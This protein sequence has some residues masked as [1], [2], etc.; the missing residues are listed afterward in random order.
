MVVNIA[1]WEKPCSIMPNV[2]C[3][4]ERTYIGVATYQEG[5]FQAVLD[6]IASGAM[7]PEGMITKK[8]KLDQVVEEGFLALV[9]DKENQVKILVES[10]SAS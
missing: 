2:L 9:N 10:G 4:K 8:I 3:F 7:R 5:D 1:I 6:A